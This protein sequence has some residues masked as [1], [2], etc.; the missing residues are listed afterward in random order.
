MIATLPPFPCEPCT[1]ESLCGLHDPL[2]GDNSDAKSD[3]ELYCCDDYSKFLF[4]L[5]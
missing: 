5:I 3:R 1:E 2:T 4:A